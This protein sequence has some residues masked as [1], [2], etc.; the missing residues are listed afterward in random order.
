MRSHLASSPRPAAS[1]SAIAAGLAITALIVAGCSSSGSGGSGPVADPTATVCPGSSTNVSIPTIDA[2]GGQSSPVAAAEYFAQ[3]G[4]VGD[5]PATGWRVIVR[6][7]AGAY[8]RSG[9][10]IIYVS[11]ASDGTWLVSHEQT[12]T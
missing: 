7:A 3:H 1:S 9:A 11:H 5:V 4:N 8:L 10:S 6:N 2:F 12:C